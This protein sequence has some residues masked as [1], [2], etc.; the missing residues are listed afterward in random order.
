MLDVLTHLFYLLSKPV[1]P[2]KVNANIGNISFISLF[3]LINI[4]LRETNRSHWIVYSVLV[5]KTG[6]VDKII[7]LALKESTDRE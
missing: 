7:L 1:N 2:V 6:H 5:I 3:Y 4:L